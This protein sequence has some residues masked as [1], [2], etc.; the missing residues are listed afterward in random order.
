MPRQTINLDSPLHQQADEAWEAMMNANDPVFPTVLVR[1]PGVL[2]RMTQRGELERFN[3]DSLRDELSRVA[4]FGRTNASGDF[5]E[6][7]PPFDVVKNI[8][9]RDSE[10]YVRGQLVDR[11]VDIPVLAKDGT[12][13][14]RPGYHEGGRLYYRPATNPDGSPLT[15]RMKAEVH[16]K[17][18]DDALSLLIGPQ[19]LL[20]DFGFTD[21]ASVAN[22][23]GL[24]L[25]P[26]VRERISGPTPLHLVRAPDIGSGKSTLATA[27]LIP[28]CGEPSIISG[29]K[30]EE[31]WRKRITAALMSG[32]NAIF[33]DNLSGTLD[34]ASLAAALT[35]GYWEDRILGE[36]TM[37]KVPVRNAWVATGN[38]LAL[39]PEQ[40]RRAVPIFLDPGDIRPDLRDQESAFAHPDLIEWAKE[41]RAAL[42]EAALTLVRHWLDG[43]AHAEGGWIY[44]R[45]GEE[46]ILGRRNM[47]SY[48]DWSRVIG[49]ILDACE[50]RGFLENRDQL[51]VE[52]DDATIQAGDF[53]EAWYHLDW[54]P[55]RAK[56]IIPLLTFNGALHDWLPDELSGVRDAD[57]QKRFNLWLRENNNR[58]INGYQLQAVEGRRKMWHV[59]RIAS[60]TAATPPSIAELV[61]KNV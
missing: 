43:P 23:V 2:V 46:P 3:P 44:S 11:V 33:L 9:E 59:R 57:L 41:N 20:G 1:E 29:T 53:L 18:L 8:L 58:R 21:E 27:C 16:P 31:E 39:A 25:L 40:V 54:P 52:A 5:I 15:V 17:D 26:F 30:N 55:V 12:L 22:A 37:A 35:G 56:D 61:S 49:G 60:D 24:L 4:C 32:T 47:G 38:N 48:L 50:I 6:K 7:H 36:S 13:I 10:R 51:V 14:E 28:S 19:G 45:T 34:S 42:A